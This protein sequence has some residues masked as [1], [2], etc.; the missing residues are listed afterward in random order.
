MIE[1]ARAKRAF[2]ASLP[3]STDEASFE[4]RRRLMQAQELKE[5]EAREDEIDALQRERLQL[6]QSAIR[7]RDQVRGR[8]S[9]GAALR[10]HVLC[11][12]VLSSVLSCAIQR[13]TSPPPAC[14]VC[15]CCVCCCCVCCCIAVLLHDFSCGAARR[16]VVRR[17][18][19]LWRGSARCGAVRWSAGGGL[20][21]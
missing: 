5:W 6:L 7:E 9:A 3:A 15:C 4:L 21:V 13:S 18:G 17:C 8:L 2:E 1:R 16:G 14:C 10:L 19:A 20:S 11:C 12:R